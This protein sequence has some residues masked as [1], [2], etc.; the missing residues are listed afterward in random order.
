MPLFS[1]T[2]CKK[3][4][5]RLRISENEMSITGGKEKESA[6]CPKCNNIVDEAMTNGFWEVT[7]IYD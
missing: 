4:H 5:T 3:C 1:E 2:T 7:Q 6:R